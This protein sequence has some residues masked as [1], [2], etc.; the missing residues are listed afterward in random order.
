MLIFATSICVS[1]SKM[2]VSFRIAKLLKK[3]PA[4]PA[5]YF[6]CH[7]GKHS[8]PMSQLSFASALLDD[9]AAAAHPPQNF[10]MISRAARSHPCESIPI[11]DGHHLPPETASAFI[12]QLHTNAKMPSIPTAPT[13]MHAMSNHAR[14]TKHS[15]CSANHSHTRRIAYSQLAFYLGYVTPTTHE[16]N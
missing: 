7:A 15:P 10:A 13:M 12:L 9:A 6:F 5:L 11:C 1:I 3:K 4:P 16:L 8:V 14:T 2:N